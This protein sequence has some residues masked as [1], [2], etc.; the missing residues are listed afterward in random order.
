MS[1]GVQSVLVYSAQMEPIGGIESHVRELCLR[2][3]AVGKRVTLVCSRSRMEPGTRESLRRAGVALVLNE[4]PWFSASPARKWLWTL[5]AL[6]RL[7]RQ[8]FDVVYT[9]GQGRNPATVMRWFLGRTRV[10]H[11]HHMATDA[12]EIRHWSSAYRSSMLGADVLVVTANFIRRRMQA[13]IGRQDVEVAYCFSRRLPA[14]ARA[15]GSGS[16]LVF[17]YFGRLIEG[18]GIDWIQRLSRDPRLAGVRWK[19]WGTEAHYRASDFVAFDNIAY[20][21]SFTDEA[22]L[23]AA[24][25]SL[26]C[27]VLLSAT[28]GLPLSL[29]EV[30]GAG[31]PWI[32]TAAGGIPELAH[33]LTSCVLVGL[34]DYERVVNACLAMEARIRAGQIDHAAQQ[35]FYETRLGERALLNRWLALLEGRP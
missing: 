16:P 12:E 7:Q 1:D 27:F 13:A 19:I 34:D 32:A 4:T 29:M 21:G 25:D 17:G 5:G 24:L 2:L 30:M 23:R 11:H 18:K 28:E 14:A 22:G 8:K 6:A 10:I 33:D 35:A 31:K 15:P 26:D 3:A 9:N 20:E